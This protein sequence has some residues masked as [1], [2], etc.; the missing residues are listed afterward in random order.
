MQCSVE[1]TES[2]KEQ[3]KRLKRGNICP[4][5]FNKK[6]RERNAYVNARLTD[7]KKKIFPKKLSLKIVNLVQD[8][9]KRNKD[10]N[11]KYAEI[12]NLMQ[13]PCTYCGSTEGYRGLDRIDSSKGYLKD[14]V[15]PCCKFCNFG[16]NVLTVQEYLDHC[17]RVV[18]FS[19]LKK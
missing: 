15:V 6:F 13:L 14:N 10:L 17:V 11:L 18:N 19:V 16:K 12:G 4:L 5:C 8:S 2:Q 9:I 3:S 1:L 7:T